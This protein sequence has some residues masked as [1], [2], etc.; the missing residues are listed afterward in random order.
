MHTNVLKVSSH[1]IFQYFAESRRLPPLPP[2]PPPQSV[3]V[4][5]NSVM[6][7]LEWR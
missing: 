2:S 5:P 1:S 4:R 3:P 7:R 6:S